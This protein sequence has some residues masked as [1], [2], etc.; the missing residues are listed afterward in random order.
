M[1]HI[2]LSKKK[3]RLQ[4]SIAF[5]FAKVIY[6]FL[7]NPREIFQRG[8]SRI[9]PTH[10]LSQNR[11]TAPSG[12]WKSADFIFE[13]L[14]SSAELQFKTEFR[15]T[16][17]ALSPQR[18]QQRSQVAAQA[19]RLTN[20]H[21]QQIDVDGRI[22]LLKMS[23]SPSWGE[24]CLSCNTAVNTTSPRALGNICLLAQC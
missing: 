10:M 5:Q 11:R 14:C 1:A 20:S 6:S 12:R 8:K 9:T 4:I 24:F 23:I 22:S 19:F 7:A 3:A 16:I 13:Q 15:N 21:K 2:R 17:S 18:R